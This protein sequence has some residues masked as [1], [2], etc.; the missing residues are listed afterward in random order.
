MK[1]KSLASQDKESDKSI[2]SGNKSNYREET[3]RGKVKNQKNSILLV[4]YVYRGPHPFGTKVSPPPISKDEAKVIRK[5]TTNPKT[6]EESVFSCNTNK[7]VQT[8]Y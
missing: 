2:S 8:S 5:S 7:E 4:Y 3:N 6:S 1:Q